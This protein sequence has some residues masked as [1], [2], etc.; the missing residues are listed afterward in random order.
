MVNFA[1][2][3]VYAIRSHKT[4]EI[5]VGSTTQPLCKRMVGHRTSYRRWV[6]D[7]SKT[8]YTSYEILKHGDAYIELLELV[9]CSCRAELCRREGELIRANT[10]VNKL[11]AGRTDKQYCQ[12]NKEHHK[13][14]NKQYRQDNKESIKQY[15]KQYRQDNKEHIKQY[16]KQY[17]QDNKEHIKQQKVKRVICSYCNITFAHGDKTKHI[18]GKKHII[19]FKQAYVECWEEPHIG[20]LDWED[21]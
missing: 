13:Q 3:K 12:D 18:K 1:N 16:R 19:N 15:T 5:Y 9:P 21:Y 4:S 20:N 17:D 14:Y 2:G 10:C 7:N 8:Y 6:A 11:I